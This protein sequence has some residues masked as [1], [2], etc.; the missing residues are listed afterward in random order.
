MT[1]KDKKYKTRDD[2]P[3]RI[4]CTDA[5]GRLPVHGAVEV[6]PGEWHLERWTEDGRIHGMSS[7]SNLDL[8][9]VKP[10]IQKTLWLNVYGA[11]GYAYPTKAE[12]KAGRSP[13]CLALIEVHVDCEE[14][15]GLS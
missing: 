6:Y 7:E 14:G 3:A 10:R 1:D 4:Y 9:E 12:A 15:H 5:G 11:V 2:R 13:A 8:I